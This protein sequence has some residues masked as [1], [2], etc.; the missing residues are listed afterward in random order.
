MENHSTFMKT[1]DSLNWI[2]IVL[3]P[4]LLFGIIGFVIMLALEDHPVAPYVLVFCILTGIVLGIFWANRIRKKHGTTHYIS[5]VNASSDI[6][7]A[8]NSK[9]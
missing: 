6:D 4:T 3:S 2:K 5:R 8:I 1:I 7:D 9:K